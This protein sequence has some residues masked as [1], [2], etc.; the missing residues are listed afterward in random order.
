MKKLNITKERFEKSNYFKNKYGKLEYVSESGKLFKTSKGKILKFNEGAYHDKTH[1][2]IR[3]YDKLP[4][5]EKDNYVEPMFGIGMVVNLSDEFYKYADMYGREEPKTGWHIKDV[6]YTKIRKIW[7]Y[8]IVNDD[9]PYH[10]D[11]GFWAEEDEI[12]D[13]YDESTKKKFG[14]K[15][16][17][18]FNKDDYDGRE[19]KDR[20]FY[21][22]GEQVYLCD[23]FYLN[24]GSE[25]IPEHGWTIEDAK[26]ENDDW[27]YYIS[28]DDDND[29]DEDSTGFWVSQDEID[30]DTYVKGNKWRSYPK[31]DDKISDTDFHMEPWNI[32]SDNERKISEE[33]TKY[34]KSLGDDLLYETLTREPEQGELHRPKPGVRLWSYDFES[35]LDKAEN[36]IRNEIE[37]ETGKRVSTLA[38]IT[39]LM[40]PREY[41]RRL[42][43]CVLEKKPTKTIAKKLAKIGY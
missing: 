14:R 32:D 1:L 33:M 43:D 4:D 11:K 39:K 19:V 31:D 22:I 36:I 7:E 18:S 24:G 40:S 5:E 16:K 21:D 41:A 8:Y 6:E 42:V 28:L 35:A 37:D 25:D 2:N 27:K 9:S 23:E 12:C 13:E 34:I 38:G 30:R 17:E 29:D 20:P 26:E 15:F 10:H 3:D